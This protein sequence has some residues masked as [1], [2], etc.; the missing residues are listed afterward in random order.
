MSL[1]EGIHSEHFL[2]LGIHIKKGGP[3]GPP[4]ERYNFDLA[5]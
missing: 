4:M 3:E 2:M 1:P 5:I